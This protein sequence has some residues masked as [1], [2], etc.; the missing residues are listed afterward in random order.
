VAGTS[1]VGPGSLRERSSG[2]VLHHSRSR[3]SKDAVQCES[4]QT[5]AFINQLPL[6]GNPAK[7]VMRA[8]DTS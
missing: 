1:C 6:G 7:M 4:F 2:H 3:L 5:A 8:F